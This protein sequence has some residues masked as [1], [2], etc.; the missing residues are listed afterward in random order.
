MTDEGKQHLVKATL[1]WLTYSGLGEEG[2]SEESGGAF[3]GN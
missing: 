3:W 1:A 2:G